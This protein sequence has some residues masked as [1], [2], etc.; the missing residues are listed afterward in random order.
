MKIKE[1]NLFIYKGINAKRSSLTCTY[2]KA[3]SISPPN[4]VLPTFT[5]KSA[6][7]LRKTNPTASDNEEKSL[8]YFEITIVSFTKGKISIG[9]GLL[10]KYN[11]FD[12]ILGESVHTIAYH[13]EGNLLTQSP[14]T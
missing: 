8:L 4:F 10:Q 3:F 11:R 1:N 9:V 2:K 5:S 6:E 14:C 13:S 7:N 12:K